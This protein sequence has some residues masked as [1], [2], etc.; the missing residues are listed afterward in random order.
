MKKK[1]K[2]L[3]ASL[4]LTTFILYTLSFIQTEQKVYQ[5]FIHDDVLN[6]SESTQTFNYNDFI[7][8]SSTSTEQ[9]S[10]LYYGRVLKYYYA[11]SIKVKDTDIDELELFFADF[12]D[13]DKAF[14]IQNLLSSTINISIYG[15]S[16]DA[17]FFAES[18][19]KWLNTPDEQKNKSW[20]ITNNFFIEIL[21]DILKQAGVLKY[22][23]EK[24]VD[25]V[26]KKIDT[27]SLVTYDTTLINLP[28]DPVDLKYG[29][30]SLQNFAKN[31]WKGIGQNDAGALNYIS[32]Q[33]SSQNYSALE[34]A[35]SVVKN[36]MYDSYTPASSESIASF[37]AFNTNTYSS[38]DELDNEL[39]DISQ[40]ND[41]VSRLPFKKIYDN[42][43]ATYLLKTPKSSNDFEQWTYAD[44]QNLKELTLFLYNMLFSLIS[45]ETW[46]E[47]L[48]TGFI[49]SPDSPLKSNDENVMGYTS[50]SSSNQGAEYSYIVL[51]GIS[52]T[53]KE[54]NSQYTMGFW[55]S[56]AKFNTLIHEFGHA[57]DAFGSKPNS[58][59]SNNYKKDIHYWEMYSGNIF[60]DYI[61]TSDFTFEFWKDPS[62][63]IIIGAIGI[64]SVVSIT[65]LSLNYKSRKKNEEKE[66]D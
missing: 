16:S 26:N 4:L 19:S 6:K 55:S 9:E 14:A 54:F 52:L 18:F 46:V 62:S 2:I 59:R 45:N 24:I 30:T 44:T 5:S 10:I 51:T 11:N 65:Y 56:P 15:S 49:V 39:L 53:Y 33:F 13:A 27:E 57:L 43:E 23:Q 3:I 31:Y 22:T 40:A 7:P 63:T 58:A 41:K 29:S 8:P 12:S 50:T 35:Y 64:V 37:N 47:N 61:P 38:F 1:F 36:W 28:S 20:E 17:E 60:G 32:K 34:K 25:I 48:L 66:K 21:P 42:L